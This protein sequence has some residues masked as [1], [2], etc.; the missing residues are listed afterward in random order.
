M[1]GVCV[2]LVLFR[3]ELA[4]HRVVLDTFQLLGD[5][6]AGL[7]LDTFVVFLHDLFHVIR[8][9]LIREVGNLWYLL[10]PG[11]FRFHFFVV[12][13]NLAVE[14]LLLDTFVEIVRHAP[15]NIPA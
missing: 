14:N 1:R 9:I 13:D 4:K 8:P 10:V 2:H 5:D 15:T 3:Q 6:A 12:H 7:C 11:R